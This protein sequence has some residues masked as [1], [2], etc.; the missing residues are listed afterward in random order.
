MVVAFALVDDEVFAGGLGDLDV[1]CEE[2]VLECVILALAVAI[3]RI[4]KVV[5]ACFADGDYRW[6]GGHFGELR[7]PVWRGDIGDVAGMD[8]YGGV[9]GAGETLGEGDVGPA[10]VEAGSDGDD[11]GDAV[12][13]GAIYDGIHLVREGGKGEMAVGVD[14]HRITNARLLLPR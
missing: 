14:E 7:G 11:P 5:G 3:G 8:S 1:F 12:F 9:D 10:I 13:L 4:V 2:L 6:V